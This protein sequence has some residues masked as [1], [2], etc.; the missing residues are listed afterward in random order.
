[1]A[2]SS[3]TNLTSELKPLKHIEGNVTNLTSE[4]KPLKH[5]EGNVTNLTSELKPLKD[6]GGDLT[7]PMPKFR[8]DG[9]R[10]LCVY[11]EELSESECAWIL[12]RL[13]QHERES[14]LVPEE[15]S[16]KAS[17]DLNPTEKCK[18]DGHFVIDIHS[19]R[20]LSGRAVS[21]TKHRTG[22][23]VSNVL[24]FCDLVVKVKAGSTEEFGWVKHILFTSGPCSCRLCIKSFE[25]KSGW[26]EICVVTRQKVFGKT[27]EAWSADVEFS[28]SDGKTFTSTGMEIVREY[29]DGLCMFTSA[30]HDKGLNELLERCRSS[31]FYG[32]DVPF[33]WPVDSTPSDKV[34]G[35]SMAVK[36]THHD[37]KQEKIVKV[38]PD[39]KFEKDDD[40]AP[41]APVLEL[42]YK[43]YR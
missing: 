37:D 30:T 14:Q 25:P 24:S 31:I 7:N 33:I 23:V 40:L 5:I 16:E 12:S 41:W 8:G 32:S 4:L 39:E 6:I 43:T 34:S 11:N 2:G 38:Y 19:L 15:K 20:E 26:Y 13:K 18:H 22:E 28:L 3:K 1:M 36:E 35:E 27:R 21:S 10:I 9:L 29:K 42:H 17:C